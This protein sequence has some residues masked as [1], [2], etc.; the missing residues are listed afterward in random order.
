MLDLTSQLLCVCDTEGR[1]VWCNLGFEGA[2][3]LRPAEVAGRRLAELTDDEGR[4]EMARVEGEVAGLVTRMRRR[5]GVWRSVEWT[6]RSTGGGHTYFAGRDVTERMAAEEAV[7]AGEA[8][9]RAIVDHSPAA[10]FVKDLSGRY[11]LVNGAWARLTGRDAADLVGH[12]DAELPPGDERLTELEEELALFLGAAGGDGVG[13]EGG[14][15]TVV[16]DV[17]VQTSDGPRDYMLSLFALR[18][19]DGSAYATCGIATDISE[20][21]RAEVALE[22]RQGVLDTILAACPDIISLID[23]KGRIRHV[24]AAEQSMLGHRHRDPRSSELFSL[25]HPDDFDHV[26]SAFIGMVTGSRSQ[27]HVRYRV[28]HADGRWITVDSRAQAVVDEDGRFVGAVVVTR[29]VSAQL[30]SE[31]RLRELRQAADKASRAKSE[32]LSRMSHELRTPLNAILGFSQLLQMDDLSLPQAEAVEHILRAGRQ[33]LELIDDVLD[34]AR[35][36]TGHLELAI[37]AVLVADVVTEAVATLRPKA[38]RAEVAVQSGIDAEE[39]LAVLADR[40]R[41]LQVV[42][43]LVSNAVKY[44]RPGG[45]VDVSCDA[46]P[47]G[48]V[49]LAVADTGRGIRPEDLGR[50]FEPFDRLGAEQSGVAGTGVGLALARSLVERMNGTITVESVPDVGSTF[51]VELPMAVISEEGRSGAARRSLGDGTH[52][53]AGF[54]VLLVEE[55]LSSR[56]LVERVLARR[57]G[58]TVLVARDGSSALAAAREHRPDLILVDLQLPDMSGSA[59]LDELGQDALCASIPVAVLGAEVGSG[60]VRR[61]LGRGVAGQLTKPIDVRALLSLVDAARAASGK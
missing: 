21:K 27:L 12:S 60:Q 35:I 41:L 34:I 29:D 22:V 51:S 44:N 56:E 54:R 42:S 3:G 30:D 31:T 58:V 24:S 15:G 48:R 33:L 1:V 38:E 11:L 52:R 36:E 40:Q 20:R 39:P 59:L 8:R 9:L 7:R 28:Q 47:D 53:T 57:P 10:I 5:D 55:D 37:R 18:S 50:V 46:L 32:F 45:R 25:V 19:E 13:V 43:H 61:L 26:A 49:R 6:V 16:R 14:V 23:A 17:R 4:E 2:L